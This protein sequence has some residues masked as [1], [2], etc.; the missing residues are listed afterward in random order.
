MVA[1]TRNHEVKGLEYYELSTT[2]RI[3]SKLVRK[4]YI[5][6]IGKDASRI[7][8]RNIRG[9]TFKSEKSLENLKKKINSMSVEELFSN[10]EFKE[11]RKQLLDE[12]LKECIDVHGNLNGSH[13]RWI[14]NELGKKEMS[15]NDLDRYFKDKINLNNRASKTIMAL[16][17]NNDEYLNN[18]QEISRLNTII[19]G[20]KIKQVIKSDL[21]GY[22]GAYDTNTDEYKMD[23][24]F[25]TQYSG[26]IDEYSKKINM[27]ELENQ[28]FESDNSDAFTHLK[29]LVK[30]NDLENFHLNVDIKK[31]R[32]H[33]ID[34]IM[35]VYSSVKRYKALQ[36]A[37]LKFRDQI[38][39]NKQLVKMQFI[40]DESTF[41]NF[42]DI[43]NTYSKIFTYDY[44]CDYLDNNLF[45]P[46][47]LKSWERG[48]TKKFLNNAFKQGHI[49]RQFVNI[50]KGKTDINYMVNYIDTINE[51]KSNLLR[52]YSG[53]SKN[54]MKQ[55]MTHKNLD[56]IENINDTN[57]ERKNLG[58]HSFKIDRLHKMYQST[59]IRNGITNKKEFAFMLSLISNNDL[60]D[61]SRN[62]INFFNTS[63]VIEPKKVIKKSYEKVKEKTKKDL[64]N[65]ELAK[66][67]G[68]NYKDILGLSVNN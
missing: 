35:E 51:G 12:K 45:K 36:L 62:A 57:N 61:S 25:K 19:E 9:L 60:K 39:D 7:N 66:Y 1:V 22:G 64:V 15:L 33:H 49:T 28:R 8:L 29:N 37:K 43:K 68:D 11:I 27:L 41:N 59:L 55:L 63:K 32:R 31:D 47:S 14:Q 13:L 58:K 34:D 53:I 30:T 48:N 65:E 20:I 16:T 5:K 50:E 6:Y 44:A 4:I 67:Y 40:N 18:L 26:L 42:N 10:S 2:I 3:T 17:T 24:E 54:R 38:K 21:G 46:I 23:N 56:F 52:R